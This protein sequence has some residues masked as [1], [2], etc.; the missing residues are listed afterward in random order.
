MATH[1]HSP[2]AAWQRWGRFALVGLLG[3]LL[4]LTVL[5]WLTRLHPAATAVLPV[6]PRDHRIRASVAETAFAADVTHG[7]TEVG[8]RL[9]GGPSTRWR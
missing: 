1:A 4:Q 9:P 3:C 7:V 8:D 2:V 6:T 5:A